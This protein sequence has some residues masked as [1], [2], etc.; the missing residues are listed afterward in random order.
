[1][2]GRTGK[3]VVNYLEGY[4]IMQG[5]KYEG[6][7]LTEIKDTEGLTCN[8]QFIAFPWARK[9]A[10]AVLPSYDFKRL[11]FDIPLVMG[12]KGGVTDVAFSPF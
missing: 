12:H 3:N 8:D 5:K 6:I 9:G 11:P 2:I 1:M 7:Q 4:P 10:V